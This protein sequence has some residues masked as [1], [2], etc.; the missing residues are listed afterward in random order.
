MK[1]VLI[2]LGVLLVII[3]VVIVAIAGGK[4]GFSSLIQAY[5]SSHDFSLATEGKEYS[6]EEANSL[7]TVSIN[8][9]DFSVYIRKT[10]D[11]TLSVKHPELK[12]G[13]VV[14]Y[15]SPID[16]NGILSVTQDNKNKFNVFWGKQNKSFMIINVPQ[17]KTSLEIRIEATVGYVDLLDIECDALIYHGTTGGLSLENC[18]V[19]NKL[20]VIGTTGA[21]NCDEVTCDMLT[22]KTSTGAISAK[23]VTVSNLATVTTSTGFITFEGTSPY[24]EFSTSTGVINF[25]VTCDKLDVETKTGAIN[26]KIHGNKEDY[27][28]FVKNSVGSCN[29]ENQTASGNKSLNARVSTGSINI[30]FVK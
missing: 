2:A 7:K 10:E 3:G 25:N 6:E 4:E 17:N 8:T 24:A 30:D 16:K 1:K 28:I 27:T 29:L 19:A 20:E 9:K 13:D 23:G 26:G 14:T 18:S 12:R 22:A 15:T 21:V 5:A 11:N